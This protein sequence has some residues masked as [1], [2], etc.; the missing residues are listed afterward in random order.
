MDD[1]PT[2]IALTEMM[3]IFQLSLSTVIAS[4]AHACAC[5][6]EDCHKTNSL[7][8]AISA[9]SGVTNKESI[10]FLSPLIS[11]WVP[12]SI[13][14]ALIRRFYSTLALSLHFCFPFLVLR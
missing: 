4:R 10:K 5:V 9:I 8:F 7:N 2:V 1:L 3:A 6:G 11:A 13:R 12:M 14:A